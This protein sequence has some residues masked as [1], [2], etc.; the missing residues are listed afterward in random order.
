MPGREPIRLHNKAS[1]ARSKVPFLGFARTPP[2]ESDRELA[3][4]R[5][6][7]LAWRCRKCRAPNQ[8][9]LVDSEAT[10]TGAILATPVKTR[11]RSGRARHDKRGTAI[12]GETGPYIHHS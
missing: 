6:C 11:R 7:E 4:A 2:E 9:K 3:A 8:L 10:E 12:T 1:R 5:E